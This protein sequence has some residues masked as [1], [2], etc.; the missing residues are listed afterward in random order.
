MLNNI[1][2]QMDLF[3][4]LVFL[5]FCLYIVLK[6]KNKQLFIKKFVEYDAILHINMEK[7]YNI[8]HKEKILVYS[9][10]A[11][12]LPE[13][14]INGVSRDFVTLVIKFLGPNLYKEYLNVYGDYET[15]VFNLLDYF[16]TKYEDDEIRKVSIQDL[17]SQDITDKDGDK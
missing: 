12:K 9:L 5:F 7:A 13:E 11:V 6:Y 4:F 16:N 3:I 1:L 8:I 17:M 14:H 10:E 15:F 2:I